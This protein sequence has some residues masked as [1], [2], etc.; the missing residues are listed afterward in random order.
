MAGRLK[1]YVGTA[2]V[3]R[4]VLAFAGPWTGPGEDGLLPDRNARASAN[5][6][7]M[8]VVARLRRL[9]AQGPTASWLLVVVGVLAV[10][11]AG[12][13]VIF[14]DPGNVEVTTEPGAATSAG[15]GQS[16]CAAFPAF[17][18]ANC[19]GWR[20]TGVALHP[21]ENFIAQSNI[22]LDSCLFDG[23]LSIQGANV[24]ITRSRIEG[25]VA[26]VYQYGFSLRDLVLR[27]VEIDGSPHGVDPAGQA[28]I[29]SDDYTCIRCDIHHTGRGANLGENVH[30]EDSYLHD[31]TYV[32]GAHQTAIGSNGGQNFA[33]VHN[34]LECR[35]GGCSAALSLYGDFAP[36]D[37]VTIERNLFNTNGGY[38][39]Y[40]GSVDGKPYPEGTNIRYR[41]NMFGKKYMPKCGIF[42]PV[43]SWDNNAGNV[44]SGNA[45]QD[46]SG[47]VNP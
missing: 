38:C 25:R 13:G 14:L 37:N 18:D 5:P 32:D 8:D 26:G 27:D 30:I 28:G 35:S 10:V 20:H 15:A 4:A 2:N 33:I 19:T 6:G 24:T 1:R 29:G 44:W 34:N 3:R 31:W 16:A 46:G 41:D 23:T 22:T 11:V 7:R 17:P 12:L 36:I 43:V 45:W 21:C 47:P 39:T 42:G 40:A 9:R